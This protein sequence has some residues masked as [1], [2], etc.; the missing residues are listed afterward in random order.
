MIHIIITSYNEPKATERAINAFLNQNI[1]K[2]FKIIVADPF[3]EVK[4]FIKEKF[5]KH[6]EVEFY[7]DPGEGKSIV[8]NMIL[9]EIYS[10]NKNDIIISTDGDVYVSDNAVRGIID[11]FK[12]SKMGIIACR[13]VSIND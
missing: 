5:S 7:L 4:D 11:Y 9:E 1:P 3:I 2:P 13:P 12:D 8:L 6:K 10:E